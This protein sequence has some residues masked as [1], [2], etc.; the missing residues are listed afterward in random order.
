MLYPEKEAREENM[1][2]GLRENEEGSPPWWNRVVVWGMGIVSGR[3]RAFT[4]VQKV[5]WC[6]RSSAGVQMGKRGGER[7]SLNPNGGH[8]ESTEENRIRH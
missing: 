7:L 8:G 1:G 4:V 5:T 3:L 6:W 2:F